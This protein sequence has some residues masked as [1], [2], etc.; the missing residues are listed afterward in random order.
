MQKHRRNDENPPKHER[1]TEHQPR[2]DHAGSDIPP[3]GQ[4]ITY[5][6]AHS[7]CG[8]PECGA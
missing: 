1:E 7:P 2:H 8:H 3:R 5:D 6:N 4:N